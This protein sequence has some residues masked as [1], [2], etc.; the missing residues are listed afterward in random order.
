MQTEQV[1]SLP[2]KRLRL[3]ESDTPNKR[4]VSGGGDEWGIANRG[5]AR[6]LLSPPAGHLLLFSITTQALPAAQLA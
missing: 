3:E 6:A 2:L 4:A 5:D 1:A